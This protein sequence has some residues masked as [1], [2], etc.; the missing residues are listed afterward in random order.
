MKKSDFDIEKELLAGEFF[1]G[2]V[3]HNE[4]DTDL[5]LADEYY[6]KGLIETLVMFAKG[7][8]NDRELI[9]SIWSDGD[10]EEASTDFYIAIDKRTGELSD[11]IED[12]GSLISFIH[13]NAFNLYR[14]RVEDNLI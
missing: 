5:W 14:V 8:V 9:D 12:V 10:F 7:D 3:E 6:K 13:N 2:G 4:F 11:M 1:I